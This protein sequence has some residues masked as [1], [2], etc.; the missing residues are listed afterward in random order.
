MEGVWTPQTPPLATPL[1][2]LNWNNGVSFCIQF[3]IVMRH[4]LEWKHAVMFCNSY[5]DPAS[6]YWILPQIWTDPNRIQIHRIWPDADP[7][8]IYQI[9][10]IY[11]RIQCTP[12]CDGL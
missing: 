4:F 5:V 7:T 10:R 2:V 9:H 12:K 3:C 8:W 6:I 11:G 1:T